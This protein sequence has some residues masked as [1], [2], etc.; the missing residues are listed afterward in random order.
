MLILP[1]WIAAAQGAMR[2]TRVPTSSQ[3]AQFGEESGWGRHEPAGSNDPFGI[4]AFNPADP[5]VI[6]M[7]TEVVGGRVIHEDQP[8]RVFKDLGAAFLFHAQLIA[9]DRRYAPAMAALPNLELFVRLMAKVYAT[10]PGYDVMLLNII[11]GDNLAQYDRLAPAPAATDLTAARAAMP[12]S[13]V[14]IGPGQ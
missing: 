7:T 8:F 3:I 14:D 10:Q 4:K 13:L 5:R 1:E 6:D 11:R 2:L 9:N 12:P